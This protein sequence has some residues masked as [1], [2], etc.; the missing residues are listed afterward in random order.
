VPYTGAPA[1]IALLRLGLETAV[2]V[3]LVV[4]VT[5]FAAGS[6]APGLGIELSLGVGPSIAYLAFCVLLL[7]L[8][9]KRTGARH[10]FAS[11][12]LGWRDVAG[13]A[14]LPALLVEGLVH[15][16]RAIL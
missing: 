6:A 2:A 4:A 5:M 3:R 13:A 1:R 11:L 7:T 12:G 14:V 9:L 8:D 16:V 10:L 15:S